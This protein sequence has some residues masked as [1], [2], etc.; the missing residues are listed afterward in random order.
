MHLHQNLFFDMEILIEKLEPKEPI[1]PEIIK[2]WDNIK[3]R[4]EGFSSQRLK[5]MEQKLYQQP[6]I[7][8][9]VFR[10]HCSQDS[11]ITFLLG[12]GSSAPSDI[13]T[14]NKLLTSL[15]SKAEK[16]NREDVNK[17][18]K[19]CQDKGISNIEDLLTAAH[20]S[21]FS[22]KKNSITSLLNYFLFSNKDGNDDDEME[23]YVRERRERYQ[24]RYVDAS[25]ISFLQETLQILFS[26]LTSTMI[27]AEPNK[28]HI[29]IAQFIKK[30]PDAGIITT[31]YD[32]CIDEALKNENLSIQKTI[33][34]NTDDEPKTG[35]KLIKMHGSINW[36]YCESC[37]RTREFDF[38]KMKKDYNDDSASY[39]VIGICNKCTGQ[40]RPLLV[41][42]LS[43]KFMMFPSLIELWNAAREKIEIAEYL[44]VVGYSFSDADNYITKTVS[45]S[46]AKNENQKMIVIT[47]DHGLVESLRKRF[48]VSIDGFDKKRILEVCEPCEDILPRILD[49]IEKKWKGDHT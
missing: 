35:I 6:K 41:P 1:D 13:P 2:I 24:R 37:Q 26:L 36:T 8:E 30:H 10:L 38:T 19:F 28:A 17:L 11:Q 18:A 14:V 16:L 29:K 12:A 39:P 20:L 31:N 5:E 3:D 42:P 48:S 45:F 21:N 44:I 25:S 46:M 49:S 40:R 47:T 43:F 22:A 33:D 15:W 34:F 4:F 27:I 32:C 23:L 9:D 7:D